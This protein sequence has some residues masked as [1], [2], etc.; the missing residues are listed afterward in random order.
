MILINPKSTGTTGIFKHFSPLIVPYGL[1]M[2]A[3]YLAAAGQK[4]KV[5]DEYV[6]EV[7]RDL[8][9]ATLSGLDKP[10]LFGL[11]CLTTNISRAH[12][13][14]GEIKAWFPGSMVILGGIHPSVLPAESLHT[15]VVDIV[16]RGE[17]EL[18]MSELYSCLKQGRDFSHI[19][20][21]S[22]LCDGS[23]RHNGEAPIIADINI[24]PDFP[25][26]L[27]DVKKYDLGFI[28]SS[29]GCPYNCIFC[30]QQSVAGRK[31]RYLKTETVINNLDLLIN[32]YGAQFIDFFD[33][34]LLVNKQRVHDLCAGIRKHNLHT[35]GAFTFQTR[36]DNVTRELLREMKSSGFRSVT[37]GFETG[38][39][40]LMQLINK[41]ETVR[42][43]IQAVHMAKELG[44][45]T[46]ASFILGLPTETRAERMQAYRLAVDLDIDYVKFNNAVPY[47]GTEL[48]NIAVREKRLHIENNWQNFN[49]IEVLVSGIFNKRGLPYVPATTTEENLRD[50]IFKYN[51]LFYLS[52][53][54][55]FKLFFNQDYSTEWFQLRKRWYLSWS[56]WAGILMLS[57][58]VVLIIIKLVLLKGKELCGH[59]KNG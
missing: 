57:L 11:S 19:Q 38:S 27:Y 54:R 4:V 26:H 25:Y 1:S 24:L 33:D 30:S 15:G 51:Y 48:Y 32:K 31:Y 9:T 55:I 8:L 20:G 5:I 2:V 41:G 6:N 58:H 13:L 56:E 17:A 16:V 29:R 35:R 22:Y 3:A 47:P 53:R 43:N 10:Y 18:T 28:L 39:E 44:F 52:P 40:R 21:I 14:A 37:F 36:G 49:A 59:F 12:Y 34:N 50:E 45:R 46:Q 42:D 23:V 7:D